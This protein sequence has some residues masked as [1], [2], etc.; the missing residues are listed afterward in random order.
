MGGGGA[1]HLFA[2]HARHI[3]NAKLLPGGGGRMHSPCFPAGGAKGEGRSRWRSRRHRRQC[4]PARAVR[5]A[6][7]PAP[8]RLPPGL[9]RVKTK[10]RG[11]DTVE[12]P[13]RDGGADP[14]DGLARLPAPSAAAP[15][16]SAQKRADTRTRMGRVPGPGM[17]QTFA[18]RDRCGLARPRHTRGHAPRPAGGAGRGSGKQTGRRYPLERGAD[19]TCPQRSRS[20]P[21]RRAPHRLGRG[22]IPAHRPAPARCR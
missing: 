13:D 14:A 11:G 21:W 18:R 16:P 22:I 10:S 19:L 7:A 1:T 9:G 8:R 15:R 12:E 5:G 3:A 2:A 6:A 20:R 17:G 4:P